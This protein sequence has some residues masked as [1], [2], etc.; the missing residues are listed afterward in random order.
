MA[1]HRLQAAT[2]CHRLPNFLTPTGHHASGID[3]SNLFFRGIQSDATGCH[4]L[5]Q[6]DKPSESGIHEFHLEQLE[7][8][9]NHLNQGIEASGLQA[10]SIDVSN[11]FFRGFQSDAT[12]RPGLPQVATGRQTFWHPQHQASRIL[13]AANRM[14]HLA[15][16]H[17]RAP[18][19]GKP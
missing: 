6:A 11:L 1:P 3:V 15:T 7:S 4:K 19:A 12:W 14:P 8:K 9:Q 10:S 13:G 18:Q 2:G 16:G 5:P 17:K